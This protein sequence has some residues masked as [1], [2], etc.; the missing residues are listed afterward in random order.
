M[1]QEVRFLQTATLERESLLPPSPETL[2]PKIRSSPGGTVVY[3][4]PPGPDKY[5][6]NTKTNLNIN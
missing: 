6:S 2:A 1:R 5:V 3:S 4:N